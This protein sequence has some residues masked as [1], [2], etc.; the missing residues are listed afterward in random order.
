MLYMKK[1]LD[2]GNEDIG[3]GILAFKRLDTLKK[4]ILKLD[5]II[6]SEILIF[7]DKDD[8]NIESQK[9]ILVF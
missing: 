9:E 6:D 1:K 5:E 2:L 7:L 3:L 4:N 8:Q